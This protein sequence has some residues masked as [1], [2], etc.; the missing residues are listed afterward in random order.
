MTDSGQPS[1]DAQFQTKVGGHS[2]RIE[3][4][5]GPFVSMVEGVTHDLAD[6]MVNTHA[7]LKEAN[8]VVPAFQQPLDPERVAA[9]HLPSWFVHG[10]QEPNAKAA[11]DFW[12]QRVEEPNALN[13]K[14]AGPN[15][16]REFHKQMAVLWKNPKYRAIAF[17]SMPQDL[18]QELVQ[19]LQSGD[20]RG[21][22]Y[23][24]KDGK[25]VDIEEEGSINDHLPTQVGGHLPSQTGGHLPGGQQGG[26]R[27]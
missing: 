14:M 24:L 22:A 16:A 10:N 9:L 20:H 5:K 18:R 7:A 19:A 13:P 6:S 3:A 1:Q 11:Q 17:Q 21:R 15:G 8:G 2:K 26:Q 25:R 23:T 4:L 12:S 27:G